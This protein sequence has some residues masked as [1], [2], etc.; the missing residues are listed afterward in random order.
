M[1]L[2]NKDNKKYI[3]VLG[4]LVLVE[5]AATTLLPWTKGNFFQ[6]LEALQPSVWVALGVMGI[7][8]FALELT[9]AFKQFMVT[10]AS[11]K[12]RTEPTHEL[13]HLR[14][15]MPCAPQRIQEDIKLFYQNSINVYTEYAIS[16]GIV[17]GLASLHLHSP[18]LLFGAGLYTAISLGIVRFFNPS[19]RKAENIVQ[20]TETALRDKLR[21][22]TEI[23]SEFNAV[24]YKGIVA[25]KIRL[26]FTLFSRLQNILLTIFPYLVLT[27]LF[28]SGTINLGQFMEISSTFSLLVLNASILI[29]LYPQLTTALACSDRIKTLKGE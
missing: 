4:L 16:L 2:I 22:T 9:Q 6:L 3:I 10:V 17:L 7:N 11:L 14:E 20:S 29:Y 12:G 28:L 15:K 8:Y 24:V 26:N 25:G 1:K 13:K 23:D 27:P 18:L 21:E 5:I 19:M